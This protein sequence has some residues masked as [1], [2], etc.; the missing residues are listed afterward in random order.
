MFRTP[1]R[2]RSQNDRDG[3]GHTTRSRP[4]LQFK[5]FGVPTLIDQPNGRRHS[6]RAGQ[7]SGSENQRT[8]WMKIPQGPAVLP[9]PVSS[10]SHGWQ[11]GT[12]LP[13]PHGRLSPCTCQSLEGQPSSGTL[14]IPFLLSPVHP[15]CS[16]PSGLG[17]PQRVSVADRG[18]FLGPFALTVTSPSCQDHW[19]AWHCLRLTLVAS[20]SNN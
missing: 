15:I 1:G 4:G 2:E 17:G 7:T 5:I 8:P 6:C 3:E 16:G 19:Q 18:P 11:I 14:L 12:S 13:H 9:S 10:G 20:F